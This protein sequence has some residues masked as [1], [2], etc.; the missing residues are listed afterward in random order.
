MR[1]TY[2]YI[3]LIIAILLL[4]LSSIFPASENLRL[5]KDLAGGTSLVYAVNLDD[6]SSSRQVMQQ[7]IEVLQD[8]VN[9]T[10][11]LDITMTPQSGNRIEITMPLP[12]PEVLELRDEYRAELEK[13]LETAVTSYELDQILLAD[14]DTRPQLI[15][16]FSAGSQR[17]EELLTRVADAHAATQAAI[18]AA[19]AVTPEDP[20]YDDLEEAAALR[21]IE[22]EDAVADALATKIDRLAVEKILDAEREPQ[23]IRGAD[24]KWKELPSKREAGIELLKETHPWQADAIDAVAEKHQIYKENAR[25]LDDPGDLQRLLRG[26]GVLTMHIMATEDDDP[27]IPQLRAGLRE[28]GPGNVISPSF[29]WFKINKLENWYESEAARDAILADAESY[30]RDVY[31]TQEGGL[32]A[33]NY[34]GEVYLLGWIAP[35]MSMGRSETEW[36]VTGAGVTQDDLG[37]PAVRFDLDPVGA[38]LMADMSERNVNRSMGVALD[39]EIYTAPNINSKLG[40]SI[41]IT[42]QFSQA[43]I[44]YLVRVL[45]AGSL[46]AKLGSEPLSINTLGPALGK[47]NLRRGLEAG[48][49]AIVAVCIFMAI[50]YFFAGLV[51]DFALICN[52]ILILGAMSLSNASFTLPGIAGV[53]LTFG[54]AVDANV[55]IYERI[56]EELAD[57]N[58]LRA[59]VRLGFERA[60]ST[61]I[62]ANITNLI[63]CFVLGYTATTEVKGFAVTLGIGIVATLFSCLFITRV[64]FSTYTEIFRCRRM[65]MLAIAVPAIQRVL[66]PKINWLRLRPLFLLISLGYVSLGIGMIMVQGE[67]M[68]D[69]EFRGGTAVT[70]QLKSE[71]ETLPDGTVQLTP[72]TM[73]RQDVVDRIRAIAEAA[74][75][76]AD[77]TNDVLTKLRQETDVLTVG[78][79]GG[80]GNRA[81]SFQIKT[82]IEQPQILSEALIAEFADVLDTKQPL[83]FNGVSIDAVRSA[84]VFPILEARVGDNLPPSYA[85]A[86]RFSQDVSRYLG[87]VAILLEDITPPASV[88]DLTERIDRIRNQPDFANTLSRSWE[89]VGLE[90]SD[91]RGVYRS[92]AIV[93]GDEGISY[94]TAEEGAWF[95]NL[96]AGEWDLAVEAMT[97]TT[98]LAGVQS[99]SSAIA[100]SFKARA[101]VSV[102]L[103]F[104]G[105]LVYIWLRFGSLRYSL[106]AIVA[107]V[108]DVLAVIGL[109]AAA[110]LLFYHATPLANLLRIEPFKIDLGLIAA[111]LTIIGYSLND[112]IV[113][114]DRIRENRGKLAYA[115]AA[116][117]NRS[118]NQTISRTLI[119]SGT[120]FVAVLTLYLIGGTGIR[121]FSYALLCGVVVGTYSSI[122]VAAPLVYSS[123]TDSKGLTRTTSRPEDE[124][125]A[126]APATG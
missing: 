106:A 22:E 111:L 10:G 48:L 100:Q 77:P 58:D 29:A 113:I 119:T 87:G 14:G 103:S 81:S 104:A 120:T 124:D 96:A 74:E 117:V 46:Q 31:T 66:T 17:I 69:T 83:D 42:G 93:V 55:L 109:I 126:F 61:I 33:E 35:D 71:R 67:E 78:T 85:A 62:D 64:V 92:A 26:A 1:N 65:S 94:F 34:G 72:V 38:R 4:F 39:N 32:V 51:A 18:A 52:A 59:A 45:G 25:G 89:V 123:R 115:S 99:F 80:T 20:A 41:R 6:E 43:E 50:Y 75:S 9:P 7:I 24:G 60:M 84:P 108:H 40:G 53:V 11:V 15:S 21:M 79:T 37:R 105:I 76:D 44:Q 23:R 16:E 114:L 3:G 70:L 118:I 110:E 91:E 19:E 5:G 56:R 28:R 125:S 121:S 63:V 86:G 30:F 88:E 8:R 27:E 12:S 73:T 97:R 95:A 13:L 2:F 112:T 90:S 102:A 36:R 116:V 54:M 49:I 98:T 57:G 47:D 82:T 107:L 68:L 122:A 101:V